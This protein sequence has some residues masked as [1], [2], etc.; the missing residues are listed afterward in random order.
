MERGTSLEDEIESFEIVERGTSLEGGSFEIVER[1]MLLEG[2]NELEGEIELEEV[3][4]AA[5][6]GKPTTRDPRI[7]KVFTRILPN[8]GLHLICH[9]K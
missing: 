3:C 7:I 8:I 2:E 9:E 4:A 1:G 6:T 5:T